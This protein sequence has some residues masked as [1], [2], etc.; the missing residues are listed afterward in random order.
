[1][2]LLHAGFDT[3]DVAFAGALHDQAYEL[4]EKV[5]ERAA[6]THQL[7][8]VHVGSESFSMMVAGHGMR[9]GYAYSADT[10]PLGAKWFFKKNTDPREWNIFASP[11]ATTLLAYGYSGTRDLLFEEL[12]AMGARVSDH[13]INRVD[14]AMDF[15]T[16]GFELDVEKF[17][18]HA[19]SKVRPHW[20]EATTE[21]DQNQPS[22]IL[23]GRR[24]ESVT[25]G[26]MPGRQIIVYD[27]RREAIARQ[28][29]YWFETWGI[30]EETHDLEVWRVEIRAGKK[31]LKERWGIRRFGDLENSIGDVFV[32]ALDKVRYL[33]EHQRDSNVSRQKQH[34]LWTK[35]REVVGLDLFQFRAGLTPDQVRKIERDQAIYRYVSMANSAALGL[36]VSL[37]LSNDE[38]VET[39]PTLS[40]E[41]IKKRRDEDR[42]LHNEALIRTRTR[43]HFV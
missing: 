36:G 20:S 31:E 21:R 22:A 32:H 29:R 34:V 13:S 8:L 7:Q 30:I 23:R 16:H 42:D 5:R 39:L 6:A 12:K 9:G 2:K 40:G 4:L 43:L 28:K 41:W 15:R 17:V 24:L 1:M 14:F 27:K 26:K 18:A 11:R 10:G 33:S 38:V 19:H 37:G 3:M 25:V 35:A